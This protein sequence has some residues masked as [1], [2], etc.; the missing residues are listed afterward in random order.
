MPPPPAPYTLTSLPLSTL[1]TF[2]TFWTRHQVAVALLII[3]KNLQDRASAAVGAAAECECCGGGDAGIG[4]GPLDC[5]PCMPCTCAS[6]SS[7]ERVAC[8]S[9][10][11]AASF[12]LL[13]CVLRGS[14]QC[15][16]C[17]SLEHGCPSG[18]GRCASGGGVSRQ[19]GGRDIDSGTD[20]GR[21][22]CPTGSI[23][24]KSR[25][26]TATWDERTRSCNV[27]APDIGS[28]SGKSREDDSSVCSSPVAPHDTWS[29]QQQQQQ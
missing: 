23:S 8:S 4:C 18:C 3:R 26:W 21:S 17:G 9:C 6:S 19:G 13:E 2:S 15:A 22:I 1:S 5:D 28:M 10:A 16:P 20:M 24:G 7:L 12:E 29:Q 27:M 11:S 14:L 25:E